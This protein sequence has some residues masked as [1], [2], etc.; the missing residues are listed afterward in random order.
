MTDTPD[1]TSPTDQPPPTPPGA[2]PGWGPPP[3]AQ[4][5]WGPPPP[6]PGG[7]SWGPPPGMPPGAPGWGQQAYAT[8]G[9]KP[10]II[11]LRPLG[12]GEILDGAFGVIREYP[13]VTI[14]LSAI[15][16]TL[17]QLLV[18][19]MQASGAFGDRAVNG[20]GTPSVLTL[21]PL[22]ILG[23]IVSATAMVVLAGMLTSVVGDAVLGRRTTVSETWAKVKPRFWTL[24]L[25]AVV[26]AVVQTIGFLA[27]LLPGLFVWV[28][29]SFITP[30]VVLERVGLRNAMSRS[31]RLAQPDFWRVLG[32][33]LLAALIAFVIDAIIIVPVL[34]IAVRSGGFSFTSGDLGV[35]QLALISA[36]GIV[37]A[38]ITTPFSAG[39]VAL[40]YIDRRMRVEAL[41]VTLAQAAAAGSA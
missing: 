36:G 4:P 21:A 15:V 30:A 9:P 19:V 26:V 18:F 10:G 1:W 11:P 33:R 28:V 2:A 14:G 29:W 23:S 12:L 24:L 17:S 32:I 3:P 35:A 40:L 8:T 27:C 6:P 13:A 25:A 41:D 37:A 39:V 20:F 31:F 38:T 16:V 34:V 7:Q 5:G 22:R